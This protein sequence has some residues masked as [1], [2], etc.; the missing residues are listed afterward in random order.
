MDE[1]IRNA[2]LLSELRNILAAIAVAA[3][4]GNH[5]PEYAAGFEDALRSIAVATGLERR[6][7]QRTITV[8]GHA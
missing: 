7:A 5:S 8:R 2:Y 4:S 1:P 6:P 3:Q